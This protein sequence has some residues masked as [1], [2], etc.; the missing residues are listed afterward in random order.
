MR[1]VIKNIH[2]KF[3]HGFISVPGQKDVYF[4]GTVCEIGQTV[5]FRV[6]RDSMGRACAVDIRPAGKVDTPA[7]SEADRRLVTAEAVFRKA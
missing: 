4:K 7:M 5:E 2:Q 6:T 3:G 1:G